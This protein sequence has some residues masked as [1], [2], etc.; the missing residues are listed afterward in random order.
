MVQRPTSGLLQ[1]VEDDVADRASQ[2]SRSPVRTREECLEQILRAFR[3][4]A[5]RDDIHEAALRLTLVPNW[6]ENEAAR[7]AADPIFLDLRLV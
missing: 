3:D 5:D 7:A 6:I 4:I 2:V 1:T